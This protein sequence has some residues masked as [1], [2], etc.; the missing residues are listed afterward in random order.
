M[1]RPHQGTA[2]VKITPLTLGSLRLWVLQNFKKEPM[3]AI[4]LLTPF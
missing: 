2:P 1:M 3:K 4:K